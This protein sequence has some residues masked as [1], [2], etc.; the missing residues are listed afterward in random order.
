MIK[1][2]SD[3]GG[4][5]GRSCE[6]GHQAARGYLPFDFPQ[7]LEHASH[8]PV[9]SIETAASCWADLFDCRARITNQVFRA[10]NSAT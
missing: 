5:A 3:V 4:E 9:E 6:G 1:L 10:M 2:R 8:E 7:G